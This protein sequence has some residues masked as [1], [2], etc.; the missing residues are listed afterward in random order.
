[1]Q[2]D[3]EEFR[4]R[5]EN[6]S[7]DA[8]LEIDRDELVEVAQELLD[9]ELESRGLL[10][11][12][13]EGDA[14]E[15]GAEGQPDDSKDQMVLAAECG[16]MQEV[17][18]ARS[19]LKSAG[20]P[21]YVQ[22]DFSGILGATEEDTRVYVPASYLEQAQE[23]LATPLSDEDLEAQAAAA[24]E[25]WGEEQEE[26]PEGEAAEGEAPQ[27]EASEEEAPHDHDSA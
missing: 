26:E 18:F 8:L 25:E 9:A 20:I 19:L 14:E 16:S 13:E 21:T 17:Q 24:G 15:A 3:P 22:T 2:V 10:E 7:D 12:P 6:L 1:M 23:I 4:R 27:E 11:E 5:F